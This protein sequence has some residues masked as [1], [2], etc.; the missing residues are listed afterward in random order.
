MSTLI[1]KDADNNAITAL[2]LKDDGAHSL[3]VTAAPARNAAAFDPATKVVSLYATGP[4][5]VRFG[6]DTVTAST[7]DH[8]FPAGFYYDIAISGGA[9]KSAQ[10]TYISALRADTDCQLFISEKQ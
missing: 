4:V 9:G 7:S 8:Y 10:D 3:S 1:N 6:D 2:R 5:Y